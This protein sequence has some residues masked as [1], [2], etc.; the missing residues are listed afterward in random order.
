VCITTNGVVTKDGRLVMGAGLAKQA[1]DRFPGIDRLWGDTTLR[2]GLSVTFW[3]P[4]RLIQFPTKHDWRQSS[5]LDLIK[6]SALELA[7]M[8][9]GL[10]SDVDPM[11]LVVLPRVGCGLG[12]LKWEQVK[13]VIEPILADNRFV[14]LTP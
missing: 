5:D 12:A 4:A 3:Y 1:R 7:R 14:V 9:W 2:R 11:S 13:P 10:T 6:T 8:T